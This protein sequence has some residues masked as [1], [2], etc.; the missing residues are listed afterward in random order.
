[1]NLEERLVKMLLDRN[2]KVSTAESCTGGLVAGK[3]VNVSGA[4]EVFDE[5]YVTYANKSKAKLL[6]VSKEILDNEGAVSKECAMEMAIGCAKAANAQLGLSTTGIAGPGGG[7]PDIYEK[8]DLPV[9]FSAVRLSTHSDC[10]EIIYDDMSSLLRNY[11][12]KKNLHTRMR[13][14]SSDLRRVVTNALEK[15]RKKFA[16]QEKQMKDT[17]KKDKYKVYGELLTTYGYSIEPG[18]KKFD[19]INFY[20]NEP[21]SI[22][23][24]P[25]ISPIENAKKFFDKYAK[26]KRTNEALSDIIIETKKSIDYLETVSASIDIATSENDLKAIKDELIQT[27]YIKFKRTGKKEK[28]VNKPL[29]FISSDGFHMY[30]GK[31]NIQNENLTFKVANGN[32]W[33]FH[34]KTFPGSHVIVKCEG[35]ELPDATFEEA[36]RL[37]AHFSKGCN[38]DKVEIDYIQRKQ[39]K[40]VA[41]AMPGFVI[42][43]TNYSMAITPDITGIQEII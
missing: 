21:I 42:Y 31:N 16:I 8:D 22:P 30:V 39:V 10:N 2:E 37:A 15:D 35:K 36:A 20:T 33:W 5:G 26:L 32:D 18:A 40:K 34:S 41:G 3:I 14:K 24:D 12:A 13:Q 9:D 28:I 1:M 11:Y 27:G 17:L 4:S 6:G 7:T 29:H 23:L 38:Q 43:H 25:T 19:T